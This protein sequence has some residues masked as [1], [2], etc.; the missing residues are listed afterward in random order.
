M[1][2][3]RNLVVATTVM[4]VAPAAL[5]QGV[6]YKCADAKGHVTYQ[7]APCAPDAEVRAARP[8]VD[9]GYNP[10]L[11][12][13]VEADRRAVEARRRRDAQGGTGYRLGQPNPVPAKVLRCRA[14]KAERE[15]ILAAVGLKRT[16]DLLRRLDDDVYEA[17]KHVQGGA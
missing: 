5:A 10:A 16:F 9:P 2:W 4:A 8:Y 12:A 11:A 1:R 14:A 3:I 6:I 13:K 7:N 15:R 17:C